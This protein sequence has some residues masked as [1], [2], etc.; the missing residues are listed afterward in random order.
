M[1]YDSARVTNVQGGS[2]KSKDCTINALFCVQYTNIQT[3]IVPKFA[4][5]HES[6]ERHYSK[7]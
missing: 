4:F 3:P 2:I 1:N 6:Y 7:M 5:K